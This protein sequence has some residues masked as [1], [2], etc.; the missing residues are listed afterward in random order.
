MDICRVNQWV[1]WRYEGSQK[2][3]YC[4]T[5]GRKASV[6]DSSTWG[7]FEDAQLV[8]DGYD[9]IGFVFTEDDPYCGVDLDDC[10]HDGLIE[11][12]AL[13]IV[14]SLDSCWEISPSGTGIH[15]YVMANKLGPACKRGGTE[16]YDHG[17]YFTVSDTQHGVIES[18]QHELDGL[19]SRVFAEREPTGPKPGEG[20][21]GDD[22]QLLHKMRTGPQGEHF[23]RLYEDGNW[24]FYPSQSEADYHLCCILAYYI[25][26]DEDRIEEWFKDSPLAENLERKPDPEQYVAG[27]IYKAIASRRYFYDEE[28]NAATPTVR[29][30][31]TSRMGFVLDYGWAGRSG[32]TDRDVYRA[33]LRSAWRYGA[34]QHGGIRVSVDDRT[35]TLEAGLGSN[36]TTRKAVKRL[37]ERHSLVGV[38]SSGGKRTASTYL[39]C[40]PDRAKVHHKRNCVF[41]GAGS[42]T[43]LEATRKVRNAGRTFGTIGKRSAQ[44]LDLIHAASEPLPLD[45]LAEHM[46]MRKSDLRRRHIAPLLDEGFIV[47]D[48]QGYATP[49]DIEQRLETFL[50]TSGSN[51]AEKLVED[52]IS[53]ERQ[54]WNYHRERV[55]A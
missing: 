32:P 28:Y 15:V 26:P 39:L 52:R 44:V 42:R 24:E 50:E 3:P 18:R 51:D 14:E 27:T 16:M 45:R 7:T 30:A 21:Q 13:E 46:N 10:V 37:D 31:I 2:V 11:P 23:R 33:L 40:A 19:Y 22:E 29:D 36:N 49:N 41:Y 20:F 47:G 34:E 9:G 17:H 12:W 1:V 55:K 5:T 8:R 38:L 48:E 54:A 53:R 43:P 4:P 6:A 35:L 25:G